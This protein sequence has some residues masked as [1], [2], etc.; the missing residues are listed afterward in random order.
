MK[1]I[2]FMSAVVAT[3]VAI[4]VVV[5]L[6]PGALNPFAT[7]EVDRSQPAVLQSISDIGQYRASSANLQLVIDLERDTRF[8]PSF[9]KGE[10]TLFVAA[11][12]VDAGVDMTQMERDAVVVDGKKATITLPPVRLFPPTVDLKKSYTVD[13]QRGVID[14]I[15]S[16]FGD[17]NDEKKVYE[18]A[19]A[20]L[21]EAAAADPQVMKRAEENTTAMLTSL[22]TSLGFEEVE[23]KYAPDPGA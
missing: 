1:F 13:R 3:V 4:V 15:G 6:L 17:G 16:V 11:G 12:T 22:L 8:V 14:R 2:K 7:R 18:M 9:I 5:Q 10:R 23:V 21:R 20:K 19:E